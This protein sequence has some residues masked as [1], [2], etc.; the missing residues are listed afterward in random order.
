VLSLHQDIVKVKSR[1]H[2]GRS[3]SWLFSRQYGA[4]DK[5]STATKSCQ[6]GLWTSH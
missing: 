3:R 6:R 1:P 5:K 4:G 2:W